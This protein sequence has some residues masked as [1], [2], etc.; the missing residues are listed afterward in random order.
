[1]IVPFRNR[2]P[3]RLTA[4]GSIVA[5]VAL[6]LLALW[7]FTQDSYKDNV[8]L[9]Y[10]D[11]QISQAEVDQLEQARPG[12]MAYGSD[13]S[14][15]RVIALV[16]ASDDGVCSADLLAGEDIGCQDW[17]QLAAE[18]RFDQIPGYEPS[19]WDDDPRPNA[20]L[21]AI[22]QAVVQ[23]QA[24]ST[25]TCNIVLIAPN[26]CWQSSGCVDHAN[27]QR[28]ALEHAGHTLYTVVTETEMGIAIPKA[29]HQGMSKREWLY[30]LAAFDG[31]APWDDRWVEFVSDL[32]AAVEK[33]L[34]R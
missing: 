28:N 18:N 12:S 11:D 34:G 24:G 16:L 2:T 19:V 9:V 4:A 10:V 31:I 26:N 30:S 7:W 32:P 8:I 33:T 21:M 22:N 6:G 14:P 1:M 23:C 27:D 3:L 17:S 13:R 25:D 29:A 5:A 15:Y 20:M